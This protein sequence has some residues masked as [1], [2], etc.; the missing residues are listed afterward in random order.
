MLQMYIKKG[1]LK[2]FWMLNVERGMMLL[3]VEGAITSRS[4]RR[5]RLDDFLHL[6][7]PL[8]AR[9]P[10]VDRHIGQAFE[11]SGVGKMGTILLERSETFV[12]HTHIE[13][14]VDLAQI[15]IFSLVPSR[16][17]GVAQE[18]LGRLT[19]LK[20]ME[21]QAIQRGIMATEYYLKMVCVDIFQNKFL[22]FCE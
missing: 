10:L 18:V 4:F 20:I 19:V 14:I 12:S 6:G 7:Y 8:L 9:L 2:K 3:N 21:S 5:K 15:D 22:D 11:R 16:Q 13:V 17:E 1:R